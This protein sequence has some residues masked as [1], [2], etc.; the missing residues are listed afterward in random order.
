MLDA[1]AAFIIGTVAA[2]VFIAFV[3]CVLK[4]WLS[5]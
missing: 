3:E 1:V 2:A 5:K 4:P